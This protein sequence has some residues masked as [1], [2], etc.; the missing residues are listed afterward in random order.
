MSH[1]IKAL[2]QIKQIVSRQQEDG[3]TVV[4]ANGCFDFLHVGHIRYLEAARALGDILVLGLNG[5]K[6]VRAIKGPGRPLMDQQER[7]EIMAALE[8]V[9]YIVVF[10]DLRADQVLAELKPDVHAKG[11]DYTSETV[12]ERDTVL[13]YGGTIAIVGDSKDHS[14]RDYLRRIGEKTRVTPR[15]TGKMSI[16]KAK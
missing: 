10:D 4:F 2:P 12:P 16:D 14:T 7:A 8:C 13:S 15:A 6:S 9:D 3:K 1:K 11:T 5:D